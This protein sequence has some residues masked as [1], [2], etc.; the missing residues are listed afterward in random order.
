MHKRISVFP[1]IILSHC[2]TQ[3]GVVIVAAEATVV[4]EAMVAVVEAT[5]VVAVTRVFYFGRFML[6]LIMAVS[7]F[8]TS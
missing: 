5:A 6:D 4:A 8:R 7:C 3:I 1:I 2:V